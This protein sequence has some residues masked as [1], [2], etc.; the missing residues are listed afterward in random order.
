[1][2]ILAPL[3]PGGSLQPGDEVSRPEGTKY[4]GPKGRVRAGFLRSQQ[5]RTVFARLH[6]IK[7]TSVTV[8]HWWKVLIFG[9]RNTGKIWNLWHIFWR[10]LHFLTIE[11]WHFGGKTLWSLAIALKSS[12]YVSH[13][14]LL[15]FSIL[16]Y[17]TLHQRNL[18]RPKA[19]SQNF[20]GI[21]N[22]RGIPPPGTM[23]E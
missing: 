18:T 10:N 14:H 3:Y 2:F 4:Q 16:D 8:I 15:D 20:R 13:C 19:Y 23:L 7:R 17:G 6:R 9:W 11:K 12:L 5:P 1:V 21:P 22:L